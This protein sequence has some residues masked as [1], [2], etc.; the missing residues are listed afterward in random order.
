MNLSITQEQSIFLQSLATTSL[1]AELSNSNFLESDC[2]NKLNFQNPFFK[3]ILT[4]SGIGNPACM[5][6]MLYSLLVIPKETLEKKELY[7]NL[8]ED[9]LDINK[10][11]EDLVVSSD[12][13]TNYSKDK[14]Y[15][16]NCTMNY[17]HH[18]RNAVSHNN[19]HY[20]TEDNINYVTFKDIN[21][22]NKKENCEIKIECI[23]VGKILE[24]LQKFMINFL[25]HTLTN[26]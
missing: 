8:N 21:P 16:S 14:T 24:Y 1:L 26:S 3:E 23:N 9:F 17:I 6:I 22:K 4:Q 7:P 20:S 25:N 10:K 18:I 19:C 15:D 11:I 12:T 2:F 13:F 5:Q